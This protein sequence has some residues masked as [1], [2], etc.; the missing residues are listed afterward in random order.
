MSVQV[1]LL[2]VEDLANMT[3][4]QFTLGHM[5]E[6]I[7]VYN[8]DIAKVNINTSFEDY[9]N[10]Q[11][12][13]LSLKHY[14]YFKPL[15]ITYPDLFNLQ[16]A[17][18]AIVDLYEKR[19]ASMPFQ[20][21]DNYFK[22]GLF[23]HYSVTKEDNVLHKLD[24]FFNSHNMFEYILTHKSYKALSFAVNDLIFSLSVSKNDKQQLIGLRNILCQIEQTLKHEKINFQDFCT[25]LRSRLLCEKKDSFLF[26]IKTDITKNRNECYFKC[27]HHT[28]RENQRIEYVI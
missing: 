9:L 20:D 21:Y 4:L 1:I 14:G 13:T 19:M 8:K 7:S 18:L 16:E 24:K 11:N 15:F 26:D 12:T 23:F 22:S 6:F 17:H 2:M 10:N 25:Q 28:L 5:Q 27:F 3:E